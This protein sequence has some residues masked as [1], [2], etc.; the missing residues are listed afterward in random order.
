M[1]PKM[2]VDA[3]WLDDVAGFGIVGS[4]G[5]VAAEVFRCPS[6][7]D[8]ERQAIRRAI[9]IGQDRGLSSLEIWTDS[10]VAATFTQDEAAARGFTVVFGARAEVE[11]AHVIANLARKAWQAGR[12]DR[13]T[14]PR[15][16]GVGKLVQAASLP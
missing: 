13:P 16:S 6:P 1:A 5:P 4:R 12:M 14:W 3:S 15:I 11:G 10:S 7:G 2:W 8:A 9:Q